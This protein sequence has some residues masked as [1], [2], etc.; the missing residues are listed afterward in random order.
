MAWEPEKTGKFIAAMPLKNVPDIEELQSG[1]HTYLTKWQSLVHPTAFQINN[2]QIHVKQDVLKAGI[3]LENTDNFK[4]VEHI[5]SSLVPLEKIF[6]LNQTADLVYLI[7]SFHREWHI[8]NLYIH[9]A[10]CCKWMPMPPDVWLKQTE[11]PLKNLMLFAFM[12]SGIK[13]PCSEADW[14]ELETDK[15]LPWK[16]GLSF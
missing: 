12:L 9:P 1:Y 10:G 13:I 6:V 16:N 5:L 4:P 8:E 11:N 7:H 3:I 2:F 15:K 14:R